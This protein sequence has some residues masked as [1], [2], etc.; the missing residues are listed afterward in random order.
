MKTNMGSLDRIVRLLIALGLFLLFLLDGN[1]KY[2]G[3][4]GFIPLITA[5]VKW[6]PLYS[7]FGI[8][9]CPVKK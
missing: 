7:L 8:N 1:V 9:T 4:I 5:L 3:F 2:L 6:C